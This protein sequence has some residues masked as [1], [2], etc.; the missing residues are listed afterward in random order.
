MGISTQALERSELCINTPMYGIIESLNLGASSGIVLYEIGEPRRAFPAKRR[1]TR[2]L[3]RP[4]QSRCFPIAW[5][6]CNW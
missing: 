4:L 6:P 5:V 2:A 1:L 3:A